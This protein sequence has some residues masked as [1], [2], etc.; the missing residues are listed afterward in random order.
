[1]ERFILEMDERDTER[2]LLMA[3]DELWRGLSP[4]DRRSLRSVSI[5]LRQGC[6]S[7]VEILELP[8]AEG[9]ETAT[10]R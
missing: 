7:M 4:P 8:S 9:G 6:D 10:R 1:M 2:D 3:I 5:R